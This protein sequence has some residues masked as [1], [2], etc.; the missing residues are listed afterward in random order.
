MY[1]LWGYRG[2]DRF[3][4][5]RSADRVLP[6]Q[7]PHRQ[8]WFRGAIDYE[9]NGQEMTLLTRRNSVAI[10]EQPFQSD[11]RPKSDLLPSSLDTNFVSDHDVIAWL[12]FERD[13]LLKDAVREGNEPL[14][15]R[16]SE[17]D[18]EYDRVICDVLDDGGLLCIPI[19]GRHLGH[20]LKLEFEL[21]LGGDHPEA[22]YYAPAHRR[23]EITI[24]PTDAM[25]AIDLSFNG[26]I[27]RISHRSGAPRVT[28]DSLSH[29]LAPGDLASL[30]HEG[31]PFVMRDR[32]GLDIRPNRP[33]LLHLVS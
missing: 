6:P 4:E 21:Q 30:L 32:E 27:H 5:R 33:G 28:L 12:V 24:E 10:F 13:D 3:G 18:T 9:V 17:N 11:L 14:S 16:V 8:I 26:S 23:F 25:E 20:T 2:Y 29:R 15:A 22:T 7:P 1:V 31:D 19:L